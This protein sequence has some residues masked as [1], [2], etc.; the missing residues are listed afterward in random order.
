[1][2]ALKNDF[3]SI[4]CFFNVKA[5]AFTLIEVMV[6]LTISS[7]VIAFALWGYL[8]V[9]RYL[10]IYRQ[11]EEQNIALSQF[12]GQLEHDI[13]KCSL[14]KVHRDVLIL[15]FPNDI[16]RE[17]EFYSEYAL[18]YSEDVVDTFFVSIPSFKGFNIP[19]NDNL[20]DEL[21]LTIVLYGL[22]KKYIFHKFYS[23]G[24]IFIDN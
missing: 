16:I 10:N 5:K 18:R 8:N 15:S 7:L 17:Y 19:D 3:K 22:E 23:P 6:T 13:Y 2:D 1:M 20:S 24:M 4:L 14:M 11:R 21:E 12:I 9:N